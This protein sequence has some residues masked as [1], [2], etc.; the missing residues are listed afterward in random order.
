MD[1]EQLQRCYEGS[2]LFVLP[3]RVL[4]CFGL[5]VLE[6][7]A[8]GLPIVSTDAGAIPELMQ[9]ILP[10]CIV[11][12]GRADAMQEKV[13]AWLSGDIIMPTAEAMTRYV[14]ERFSSQAIT[15]QILSFVLS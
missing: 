6:S 15:P 2:D 4:E 11:P 5:I 1:Y 13:A 9:P 7:L 8:F 12:A 14:R 10:D 3:T